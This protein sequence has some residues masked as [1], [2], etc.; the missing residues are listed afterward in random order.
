[1]FDNLIAGV[2]SKTYHKMKNN[3]YSLNASNRGLLT[4]DELIHEHRYVD[5]LSDVGFKYVF[6]RPANKEILI[7][8]LNA[9]IQDKNIV[10]LQYLRNEHSPTNI[11]TKKSLFD[12]YCKTDDGSRIIVE[13]QK[14]GQNA[15]INRALY[16]GILPIMEQV[17]AGNK[18]YTFDPVYSINILDFELFYKHPTDDILSTYRLKELYRNDV[19]TEDFTM[20]FIELPKFKKELKELDRNNILEN[21]Y[22]CLKFIN[23]HK[24][25]PDSLSYGIFEKLFKA[26]EVAAMTPEEKI[27][28]LKEMNTERDRRNQLEY[29]LQQG[30]QQGIQQGLEDGLKKGLEQGRFEQKIITAKKLKDNGIT[31]DIIADCTGLSLEEIAA[32]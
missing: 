27:N 23:Q 20:I 13:M 1:M 29:K 10:D 2:S 28:Y 14:D 24:D 22:F 11:N 15:Y 21:F 26:A 17:E 3:N 30:I 31:P 18:W 19:L 8:F 9:V 5:L 4:L 12:L 32:L 16:Y 6:G 25:L 7:A